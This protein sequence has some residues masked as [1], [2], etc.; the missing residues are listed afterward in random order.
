MSFENWYEDVQLLANWFAIRSPSAPLLL[1]GFEV[2]AVLAAKI[3]NE[4]KGDA[5]LLWSAPTNANHVLCSNLSHWAAVEKLIES[6]ENRRPASECIRQLEQDSFVEA[7]GYV[8][9]LAG[10]NSDVVV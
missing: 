4:G 3:F 8:L 2:G 1:H 9:K 6:P 10:N 7:Y 5:L